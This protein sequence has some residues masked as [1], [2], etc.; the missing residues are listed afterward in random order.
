[1]ICSSTCSATAKG[2]GK[3]GYVDKAL[4]ADKLST[5]RNI[6]L[7]GDVT[8]TAEGVDGSANASIAATLATVL[9]SPGT[10]TKLTVNGKGLVTAATSLEASDIPNLTSSKITDLGDVATLSTGTG[11]GNVVVVQS[12]GYIDDSVIPKIA[13]TDTYEAASQVAMLAL[14]EAEVGDICIRS[15][16]NKTFILKTAPYSTSKLE[17]A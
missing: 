7:T 6:A 11:V 17:R 4:L 13:I 16:L 1:M 2:Q 9:G 15:D 8:G 10:Y 12:D 5:G 3:T 14:A